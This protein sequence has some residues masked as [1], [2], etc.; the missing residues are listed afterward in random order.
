M[1]KIYKLIDRDK[2]I[3][4]RFFES[5]DIL[6]KHLQNFHQDVEGVSEKGLYELLDI[7]NWNIEE[8]TPSDTAYADQAD[9]CELAHLLTVRECTIHK[10]KIDAKRDSG[11]SIKAERIYNNF[12]SMITSTLGL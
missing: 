12:Y 10:I 3:E 6:V 11:Y 8:Y 5:K 9:I 4:N 7:G 1:N 2:V